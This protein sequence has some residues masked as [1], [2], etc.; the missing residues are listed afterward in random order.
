MGLSS[1]VMFDSADNACCV[2]FSWELFLKIIIIKMLL[3]VSPC[4]S[5]AYCRELWDI[6]LGSLCSLL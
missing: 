6:I 1:C 4:S 2:H 3:V 5:G